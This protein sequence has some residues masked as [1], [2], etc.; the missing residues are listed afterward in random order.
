MSDHTPAIIAVLALLAAFLISIAVSK[1]A[2]KDNF[3]RT[4]VVM[5][6]LF[7]FITSTLTISF[8]PF[9]VMTFPYA[10]PALLFGI[11]LGQSIGVRTEQLKIVEHGIEHYMERF[12]HISHEDVKKF[13]WWSLINFYS[14][15]CGL[16]LINLIGFTNIILGGSKN[17]IIG[18]SVA[19]ALFV[20]S[21][22][23]YLFHLWTIPF[24]HHRLA[25]KARAIR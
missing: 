21:I 12:A 23:P 7:L 13:T 1:Y 10:L 19:G 20:G 24:T 15:M 9:A 17:F 6:A 16:V 11:I 4:R 5:S 3:T 18:T 8:W 14:I 22:V 2:F 25:K